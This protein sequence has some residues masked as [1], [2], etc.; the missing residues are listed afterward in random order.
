VTAVRLAKREEAALVSGILTEACHWMERSGMA[1]WRPEQLTEAQIAPDVAAGRFFLA[2]SRSGEALGT[3]RLTPSDPL[4][5]PEAGPDEA[6]YLHRLAVRRSAAGGLVATAL[7][8]FAADRARAAQLPFVRLDVDAARPRLRAVY[9]RFGFRHH[10]DR[11]VHGLVVA[12][13]QLP[14][15]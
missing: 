10:S 14:T 4:F 15:D 7:L 6:L 5:W 1:L 9:E 8:R 12:R 3:V 2:W 13:Y 11:E